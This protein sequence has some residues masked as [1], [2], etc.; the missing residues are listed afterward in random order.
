[1][2]GTLPVKIQLECEFRY[3]IFKHN[4]PLQWYENEGVKI[5]FGRLSNRNRLTFYL[6][7]LK[8]RQN[9]QNNNF[10]TLFIYIYI[11]I[12][13]FTLQY[14]IG[15]AIHQHASATGVH[16]F[17]ILNPP[18]TSLSVPFL[19]VIPVHQ[20]QA[21]VSCIKPGLA[22]HFLYNIICVLMPFSQIIP[23]FLSHRVQKTV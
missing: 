21:S 17:R 23:P 18:P 2:D 9:I 1:M 7:R 10:Q 11:Y 6:K 15:F 4:A 20:P 19:W 5:I 22:I 8:I 3:S 16:M 14:C 12:Y 13:F